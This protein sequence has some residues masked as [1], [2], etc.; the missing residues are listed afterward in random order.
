MP[1]ISAGISG[2]GREAG[3]GSGALSSLFVP[4]KRNIMSIGKCEAASHEPKIQVYLATLKIQKALPLM[5]CALHRFSM[6]ARI[7]AA[8]HCIARRD[9]QHTII[10]AYHNIVVVVMLFV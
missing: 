2:N 7:N 3:S 5:Q 8:T 1:G 6:F 10:S 4:I 9:I